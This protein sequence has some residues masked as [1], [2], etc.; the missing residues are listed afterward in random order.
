M[1]LITETTFEDVHVINEATADGKKRLYIEGIY[2]QAGIKNRNGRMY[3]EQV[4]DREVDRY[5][6]EKVK[7]GGAYG[8]LGHP[9]GPQ[10]NLHLASHRITELRKDGTNYVGKAVIL[11]EGNGKIVHG[12]IETGGRLGVSSRGLGSLKEKSGVMEVQDDF[13]LATA[14]DIVSD[15]S[16]PS[17][18]VNGIMEGVDFFMSP[19]GGWEK[20]QAVHEM[21]V[22]MKKMSARELAERKLALWERYLGIVAR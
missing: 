13:H 11:P 10:I 3:P 21:K 19:S 6:T 16:A 15:P 5:M 4:M 12:I 7:P 22:E 1:K 14:A 17:A 8:E 18:F 9:E 20:Q 2:L